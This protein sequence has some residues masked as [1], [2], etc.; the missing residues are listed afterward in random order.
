MSRIGLILFVNLVLSETITKIRLKNCENVKNKNVKL[1]LVDHWDKGFLGKFLFD[2]SVLKQN[3][4]ER[5]LIKLTKIPCAKATIRTWNADMN[6]NPDEVAIIFSDFTA[7]FS[8]LVEAN[9]CTFPKGMSGYDS[10][11]GAEFLQ[12]A[13]KFNFFED[14]N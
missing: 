1:Y 14:D 8:I 10:L 7:K 5:F 2:E 4:D 11:F 9:A 3:P 13:S 12:C 6:I